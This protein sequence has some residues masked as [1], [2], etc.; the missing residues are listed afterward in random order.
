MPPVG[1]RSQRRAFSLVELIALL[2]VLAVMASTAIP[3]V[4]A[5]AGARAA[6]AVTGVG[7]AL[8]RTRA[9]AVGL[10]TPC[11]IRINRRLQTIE[12]L[13]LDG[14]QSV[15][16]HDALGIPIASSTIDASGAAEVRAV[17]GGSRAGNTPEV[18]F[19]RTGGH[20]RIESDGEATPLRR[21]AT[22]RFDHGA[23][24]TIRGTSGLIE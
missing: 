10:G 21:D 12:L 14:D 4:H 18:W 23:I 11:G 5:M 22:I 6:H 3:A 17:Q 2:A 24:I 20:A 16:L 15:P 9:A 13:T 7:D 1:A 19:D 8:R